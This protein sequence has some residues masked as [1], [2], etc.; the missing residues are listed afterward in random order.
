MSA[1]GGGALT[2]EF[3][4]RA[5]DHLPGAAEEGEQVRVEDP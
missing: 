3:D 1:E 2:C 5:P 4:G